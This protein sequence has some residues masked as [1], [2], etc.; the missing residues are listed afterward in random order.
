M[1]V[2]VCVCVRVEGLT[3]LR[4]RFFAHRVC[5]I[6]S[7]VDYD[8][9]MI[10]ISNYLEFRIYIN[11]QGIY[12]YINGQ[13]S[14]Q[15]TKRGRERELHSYF[16]AKVSVVA[17]DFPAGLLAGHATSLAAELPQTLDVVCT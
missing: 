3:L 12:M 5:Q 13:G 10:L 6:G 16:R 14:P 2:C 15:H 8:Q 11:G 17:N 4:A 1:C 7:W 9:D